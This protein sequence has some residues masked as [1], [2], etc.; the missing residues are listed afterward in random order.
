[1]S[2]ITPE[3]PQFVTSDGTP[4]TGAVIPHQKTPSKISAGPLISGNKSLQ[5]TTPRRP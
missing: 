3:N 5:E 1:M 2:Q 4:L